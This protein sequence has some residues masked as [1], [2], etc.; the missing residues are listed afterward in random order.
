MIALML[1]Y[2]LWE[3]FWSAASHALENVEEVF[4]G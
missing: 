1:L 4:Y 3:A 2:L